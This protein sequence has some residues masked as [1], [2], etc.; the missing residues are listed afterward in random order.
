MELF[1]P[2][3]VLVLYE[4][5][6]RTRQ[7]LR[8]LGIDAW[9]VDIKPA[10]DGS[11]YHIVGDAIHILNQM[12][13]N[14]VIA[15]P[16]CTELSILG[17]KNPH[18][19]RDASDSGTTAASRQFIT[20]RNEAINRFIKIMNNPEI[21]VGIIENPVGRAGTILKIIKIDKTIANAPYELVQPWEFANTD[22]TQI[23]KEDLHYKKTA[24][25]PFG[26]L[27]VVYQIPFPQN[28]DKPPQG[29]K[30]NWVIDNTNQTDRSRT[31]PGM[32][33]A[34]ALTLKLRYEC[35]VA[36]LQFHRVKW[37]IDKTRL[38]SSKKKCKTPNCKLAIGHLGNCT[39][40]SMDKSMDKNKLIEK[41]HNKINI[42]KCKCQR[43]SFCTKQN[44]H[45]GRCKTKK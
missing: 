7:C 18:R 40:T 1:P 25:F 26:N 8:D 14:A 32:A 39:V 9:S 11:E 2:M 44:G 33:K 24:L 15:F 19:L 4:C 30:K 43:N 23:S 20:N 17:N 28:Y 22:I 27:D 5:S 35:A 42:K 16:P 45:V 12:K 6:G 13:P 3:R 36:K 10:E 31:P 38:I 34:L 21:I 41:K 37:F 29:T